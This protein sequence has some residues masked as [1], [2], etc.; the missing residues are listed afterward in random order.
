MTDTL[1]WILVAVL[2]AAGIAGAVLP[3]LPGAPLVFAGLLVAAWI[4]DFQR[5]G[6]VTLT[7][8]GLLA[9]LTFVVDWLATV[10]GAQRVGASRT[11]VIGAVIG[12]VVGLPLGLAGVVLGPLVG[13]VAGELAA[14]RSV[15][16]A[17]HVGLATF[18]GFLVGTVVKLGVICAMIGIFIVAYLLA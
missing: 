1:L 8:L 12:T 4:D 15:L 6:A 11:A 10:M 16:R 18:L 2:V 3:A 9:A 7:V 13:A 17:G 14:Q 5:V